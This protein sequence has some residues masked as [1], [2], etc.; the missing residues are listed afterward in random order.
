MT[1]CI[2]KLIL[3]GVIISVL[4]LANAWTIAGV[5]DRLGVVALAQWLRDNFVT[6]TAVTVIIALL[7]LLP[8]QVAWRRPRSSQPPRCPVCD[9]A[10]R[11]GGRYC[12]ACG[13]RV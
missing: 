1:M 3:V 12:P 13:S 5:F 7:I 9:E 8:T 2:R 4:L 6:G 11:R 10:L